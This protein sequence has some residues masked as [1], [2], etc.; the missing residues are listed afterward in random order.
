[1]SKNPRILRCGILSILAFIVASCETIETPPETL[2]F[3]RLSISDC[4]RRLPTGFK[5]IDPSRSFSPFTLMRAPIITFVQRES[6]L[7]EVYISEG[8]FTESGVFLCNRKLTLSNGSGLPRLPEPILKSQLPA[9]ERMYRDRV[10]TR[11]EEKSKYCR[12]KNLPRTSVFYPN[13]DSDVEIMVDISPDCRS[14]IESTTLLFRVWD[15]ERYIRIMK[16]LQDF[17]EV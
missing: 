2:Q 12:A 4:E 15:G 1:M 9:L 13:F 10:N 3:G 14:F 8:W 7:N 11:T 16:V 6:G 5:I 17:E